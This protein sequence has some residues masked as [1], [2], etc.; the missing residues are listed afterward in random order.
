MPEDVAF[1]A[2]IEAGEE[3]LTAVDLAFD[4]ATGNYRGA[5]VGMPTEGDLVLRVE[6]RDW[7]NAVRYEVE[8]SFTLQAGQNGV[9]LAVNDMTEA[10]RSAKASD[11]LRVVSTSPAGD[12]ANI[13]PGTPL[14]VTFDQTTDRDA[15]ERSLNVFPGAYTP[16]ANPR[17]KFKKLKLTAMCDGKFRVQ[18]RND[19]PIAFAW[20]LYKGKAEGVGTVPAKSEVAFYTPFRPKKGNKTVRVFVNGKSQQAKAQKKKKTCT[21]TPRQLQLERRGQDRYLSTQARARARQLHRRRE[22]GGSVPRRAH[23][24]R[25]R[26]SL[27]SPRGR[28]RAPRRSSRSCL[29]K[30]LLT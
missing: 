5:T 14:Q 11:A 21:D 25:N 9:E 30:V 10:L 6:G 2:F 26:S 3:G 23:S 20:D 12:A 17:K 15:V 27:A 8:D 22:Y 7:H 16:D 1:T 19:V 28:A 29:Q 18:N 13:A 24:S 4:E